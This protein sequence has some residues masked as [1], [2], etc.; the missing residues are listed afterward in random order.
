MKKVKRQ[1]RVNVNFGVNTSFTCCSSVPPFLFFISC[2]NIL[3]IMC[4]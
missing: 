3:G 1:C 2:L 4:G